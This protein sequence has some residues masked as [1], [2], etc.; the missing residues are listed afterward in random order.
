MKGFPQ[1]FPMR[2]GVPTGIDLKSTWPSR[3]VIWV[4]CRRSHRSMQEGPRLPAEA[5]SAQR[6]PRQLCRPLS[7]LMW[8]AWTALRSIQVGLSECMWHLIHNQR[9]SSMPGSAQDQVEALVTMGVRR[10]SKQRWTGKLGMQY[11]CS[12]N[13]RCGAGCRVWKRMSS[14][15]EELQTDNIPPRQSW[16]RASEICPQFFKGVTM[17]TH[18]H[19]R[20]IVGTLWDNT[21][22]GRSVISV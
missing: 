1:N 16:A 13:G 15:Q 19:T 18:T 9:A 10:A 20:I 14:P 2:L 5:E 12:N 8:V 7:L 17:Q 11:R 22:L 3:Q 21:S 4:G 6:T